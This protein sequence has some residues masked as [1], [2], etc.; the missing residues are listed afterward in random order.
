[1][2]DAGSF[3]TNNNAFVGSSAVIAFNVQTT[4]SGYNCGRTYS[5]QAGP[6]F[7]ARSRALETPQA[8]RPLTRAAGVE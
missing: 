1:M 3:K 4:Q 2:E 8:D 5:F 7:H 6:P